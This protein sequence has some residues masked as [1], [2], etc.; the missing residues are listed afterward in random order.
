MS[1]H[2]VVEPIVISD[3]DDEVLFLVSTTVPEN[4]AD[5]QP[6]IKSSRLR[7]RKAAA[8]AL[9]S[10]ISYEVNIDE[11]IGAKVNYSAAELI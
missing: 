10:T 3:D 6:T 4:N 1:C 7:S 2:V 5:A 8:A 9:S 11:I